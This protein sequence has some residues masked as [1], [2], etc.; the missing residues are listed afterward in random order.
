[1]HYFRLGVS[2]IGRQ[3]R[4]RHAPPARPSA[5]CAT[6]PCYFFVSSNWVAI[7]GADQP[8]PAVCSM[9]PFAV[10]NPG[11]GFPAPCHSIKPSAQQV[12]A[13]VAT[14]VHELSYI[15]DGSAN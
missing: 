14:H 8:V 3:E 15:N 9:S 6:P 10:G 2:D 13:L 4:A 12:I 11:F 5:S 7:A 1:M